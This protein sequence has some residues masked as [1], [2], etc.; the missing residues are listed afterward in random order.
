[1]GRQPED[2][3]IF[4]LCNCITLGMPRTYTAHAM[5][6]D[7]FLKYAV[8]GERYP[9]PHIDLWSKTF[10]KVF[11]I[12]AVVRVFLFSIFNEVYLP[13]Y[14]WKEGCRGVEGARML[15]DER[16]TMG[17]HS[18]YNR[19]KALSV[20][21]PRYQP[22]EF[23]EHLIRVGKKAD[24]IWPGVKKI[25]LRYDLT[26]AKLNVKEDFLRYGEVVERVVDWPIVEVHDSNGP[27]ARKNHPHLWCH[28]G[29]QALV[30][31][32]ADILE[33]ERNYQPRKN[34]V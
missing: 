11:K 26:R 19:L 8:P 14:V 17:F 33:A 21:V 1:M 28:Y 32:H 7:L 18:H 34:D 31:L 30:E 9:R 2:A 22:H 23:A 16:F 10:V 12:P 24:Q 25:I 6:M 13:S 15:A 4:S 29:E 20:N 27:V 5:T 3:D